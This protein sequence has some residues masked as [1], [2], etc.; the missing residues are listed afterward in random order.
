M[1]WTKSHASRWCQKS[2]EREEI[3]PF[4]CFLGT[5]FPSGSRTESVTCSYSTAS[6]L[7]QLNPSSLSALLSLCK[8]QI[9]PQLPN[10]SLLIYCRHH[11]VLCLTTSQW[12]SSTVLHFCSIPLDGCLAVNSSQSLNKSAC[13]RG[14][15]GEKRREMEDGNRRVGFYQL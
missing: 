2:H 3:M 4:P 10:G 11:S 8:A 6:T 13:N 9:S 14:E 7:M 5:A 1:A 15:G 12:V